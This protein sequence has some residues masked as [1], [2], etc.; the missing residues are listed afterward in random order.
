MSSRGGLEKWG[1]RRERKGRKGEE[2]REDAFTLK[3]EQRRTNNK[4]AGLICGQGREDLLIRGLH[5]SEGDGI[6]RSV[7]RYRRCLFLED[8]PLTG[9]GDHVL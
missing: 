8:S 2:E 7:S 4:P 6:A 5:D 1:S 3:K 9:A